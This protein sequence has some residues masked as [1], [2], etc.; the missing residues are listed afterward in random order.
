M[1]LAS[2]LL[3]IRFAQKDGQ[4]DGQ[5]GLPLK[6]PGLPTLSRFARLAADRADSDLSK[7]SF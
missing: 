4:I 2:P 6:H 5:N 3:S 1:V 7:V